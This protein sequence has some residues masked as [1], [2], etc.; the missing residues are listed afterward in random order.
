L[1][2]RFCFGLCS[3]PGAIE[4]MA[5]LPGR[6]AR[7]LMA[8]LLCARSAGRR[9]LAAP[10]GLLSSM[11]ENAF[12]DLVDLRD[13]HRREANEKQGSEAKREFHDLRLAAA[14]FV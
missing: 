1:F 6:F 5:V 8:R 4:G 14:E 11:V 2:I 12:Y 9:R 13:R 7:G 3:Q 10:R